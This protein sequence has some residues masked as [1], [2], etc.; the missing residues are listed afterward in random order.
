MTSGTDEQVAVFI[1]FENLALGARKDFPALGDQAVPASALQLLCQHRGN[2]RIR[3]AYADWG[4]PQFA[5]Y[6][7]ALALNGMDLIQ[8]KRFGAQHKNAADIRMAVDAME[9]LMTHPEVTT[10]V[11]VAGDGDYTPLVQRLREYGKAVVGVGPRASASPRLVAVCSEYK[12]WSALLAPDGPAVPPAVP[13][14]SGVDGAIRVLLRAIDE[15]A[16]MTADGWAAAGP[17]KNRM[18][19]INAAF[20]NAEYGARTFTAFLAL[21]Y[22]EAH[23]ETRRRDDG[24][25]LARRRRKTARVHGRG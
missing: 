14:E 7:E 15:V 4:Q 19:T 20:D 5:L 2:A 3:R 1:D 10:F 24:Q 13:A 25:T 12:Y 8:V 18:L 21:P 23:V 16:E 22:V 17:L 11:L 6:Q 9:T